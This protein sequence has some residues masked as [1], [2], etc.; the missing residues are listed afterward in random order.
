MMNQNALAVSNQWRASGVVTAAEHSEFNR[1]MSTDWTGFDA[2]PFDERARKLQ[3]FDWTIL[4]KFL[5]L[6]AA[7][8]P[9]LGAFMPFITA[10][11]A[12][13]MGGGTGPLPPLPPNPFPPFP[14]PMPGPIPDPH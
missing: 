11:I 6:I 4:I 13:L 1:F 2:M 5:P 8:I 3:A 9:G 14:G 7:F 12:W 10:L